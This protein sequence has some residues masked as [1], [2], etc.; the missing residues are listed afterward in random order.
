MLFRR[1]CRDTPGQS[2]PETLSTIPEFFGFLGEVSLLTLRKAITGD[3]SAPLYDPKWEEFKKY[4]HRSVGKI[5][6][7]DVANQFLRTVINS[8]TASW[9][10]QR[11]YAST[12]LIMNRISFYSFNFMGTIF[13]NRNL[14]LRKHLT[15]CI[16]YLYDYRSVSVIKTAMHLSGRNW[17]TYFMRA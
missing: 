7:Y 8:Q 10:E 2:R 4:G 9:M 12:S 13:V 16:H 11:A 6:F 17:F 1:N 5:V 3:V 15:L 14:S